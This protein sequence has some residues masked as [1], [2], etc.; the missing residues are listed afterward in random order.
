MLNTN[1]TTQRPERRGKQVAPIDLLGHDPILHPL[2]PLDR[3]QLAAQGLS[4]VHPQD[5][6]AI[7]AQVVAS[8][9]TAINKMAGQIE[10]MNQLFITQG[11]NF[12]A[13][14]AAVLSLLER[15]SALHCQRQREFL[16]SAEL[17]H[18]LASPP[19]RPTVNVLSVS[20]A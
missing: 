18:R 2:T 5:V 3:L 11:S 19:V 8:E 15:M 1:I 20:R 6:T 16:K 10:Q 17:L 13:S 4:D 14:P 12:T 7:V 9:A